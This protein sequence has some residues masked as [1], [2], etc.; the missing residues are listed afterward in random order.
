MRKVFVEWIIEESDEIRG[1]YLWSKLVLDENHMHICGMFIR[2][3]HTR[4]YVSL[5]ENYFGPFLMARV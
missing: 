2:S 5:V 1:K 3:H 4:G